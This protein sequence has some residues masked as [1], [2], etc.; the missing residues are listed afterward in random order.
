MELDKMEFL[1]MSVL[2]GIGLKRVENTFVGDQ[3]TVRG[4][5]GGEK[6]RV[7]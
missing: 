4:V 5:S 1:V 7:T 6:K 2:T 3:Q